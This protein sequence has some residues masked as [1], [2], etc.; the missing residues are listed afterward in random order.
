MLFKFVIDDQHNRKRGLRVLENFYSSFVARS[1]ASQWGFLNSWTFSGSFCAEC[2]FEG[3]KMLS[4]VW[5][6]C[7]FF[8]SSCEAAELV[9]E[10]RYP[11]PSSYASSALP[12]GK[13]P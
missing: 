13:F 5:C 1:I 8:N 7:Y 10:E 12:C 2:Q 3:G 6:Y 11:S 9:C 4:M